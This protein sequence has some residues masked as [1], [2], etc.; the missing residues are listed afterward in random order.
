MAQAK[1]KPTRTVEAKKEY[2]NRQIMHNSLKKAQTIDL[3][4]RAMQ[5]NTL[6][7]KYEDKK[8]IDCLT[9]ASSISQA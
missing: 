9:K 7:R 3:T 5:S 6:P 1:L 4:L 8:Q 2:P